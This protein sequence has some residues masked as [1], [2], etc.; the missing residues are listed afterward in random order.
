MKMKYQ[1]CCYSLNSCFDSVACT[2][3]NRARFYFALTDFT[4]FVAIHPNPAS[5]QEL[6][7]T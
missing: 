6:A 5:N 2:S 7:L 1:F 3:L 4:P